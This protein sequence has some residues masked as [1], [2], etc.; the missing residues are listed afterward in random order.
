MRIKAAGSSETLVSIYQTKAAGSS[1]TLVPIYQTKL[2]SV[3]FSPQATQR[4]SHVGKVS[5]NFCG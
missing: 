2:N 4:P 1:E 5:A 3:A